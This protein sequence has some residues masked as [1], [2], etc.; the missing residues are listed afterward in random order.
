MAGWGQAGERADGF[1]TRS[2]TGF[3]TRLN[4]SGDKSEWSGT[5]PRFSACPSL[6]TVCSRIGRMGEMGA[7]SSES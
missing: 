4:T 5:T 6:D 7:V 1:K 2:V 3:S